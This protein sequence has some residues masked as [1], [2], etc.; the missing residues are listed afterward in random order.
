MKTI[1]S[2]PFVMAIL[3]GLAMPAMGT[4][5]T[6]REVFD[7]YCTYCHGAADGPGTMQLKRTRGAEK[8]LLVQR[9]DLAPEYIESVVRHGLKAMPPFVPSD[10]TDTKLKALITFLTRK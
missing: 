6:G 2:V 5:M 7:H 10:L 9:T 8:A 1:A 4:E 3:A